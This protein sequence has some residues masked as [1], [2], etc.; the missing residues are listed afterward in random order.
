MCIFCKI[1]SG[2][3]PSIKVYEDEHFLAFL[4]INPYA[5]GHTLVIPKVH[6]ESLLVAPAEVRDSYLEVVQKVARAISS[7]TGLPDCTVLTRC[8]RS[9]GQE[10]NHIHFHI[11]P[12]SNEMPVFFSSRKVKYNMENTAKKIMKMF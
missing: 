2:D 7:A 8:G 12:S 5:K 1:V 6:T 4:D 10:V 3:I 9:T 11:V